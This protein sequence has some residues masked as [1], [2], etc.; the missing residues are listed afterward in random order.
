MTVWRHEKTQRALVWV[1]LPLAVYLLAAVIITWPLV[2]HLDSRA[3]GAGYGDSYEVVRHAWWARE[4][5]LDGKNPFD[6]PLLAYPDGFM[7]WVQWSHPLQYIPPALLALVVSPLTAFNLTLLIVLVLNGLTAYWLVMHLTERKVL[8]ALLGGLVFLAFPTIQGHL[9][10]GHLGIITLYPLPLFALCL[11]R[12]LWEG[13]GWR[14]AAWGA[15]WFALTALAYV[16]QLT[17][18]LFPLVLFLGL[19]TLAWERW[20]IIRRGAP[21]YE[22]PWVRAVVMCVAGG[23]LL[24][25]FYAPLLTET[26]RAELGDVA[27]TGRVTYSADLLAFVSPSPFGPLEDVGLLPDYAWDVLGTNSAEGSAY[28]GLGAVILAILALAR[29]EPARAWGVVALGAMLFS[30]GPLLKWRDK[31]VIF[32][33]EEFQSYVTLPWALFQKLPIISA[34]RTPGRFNLITGLAMS[35]LAGLGAAVVLERVRRRLVQVGLTVLIGALVLIEYQL[36]APFPTDDARQP[37]Y[38]RQLAQARDVRAVLDLPVPDLLA[39]KQALYLQT[40]HHHALVGGHALR[41]TPQDPAL[42]TLLDRAATRSAEAGFAPITREAVPYLLSQA[43]AD[44]VI[45][46]KQ[47]VT[48]ASQVVTWLE[49]SLGAPEFEDER[50]AVFAVPRTPEPPPDFSVVAVAGQEG[51]SE[52][53]NIGP[54]EGAFLAGAGD[55]YLYAAGEQYGELVFRVLPYRVP[56]RITVRLDD[57]LITGWATG[58]GEIRLPLWLEPGFHILRLV[59]PDG[60]TEY[61]FAL[62]CWDRPALSGD[63]TRL[64]PPVCISAAFEPPTW[65]PAVTTPTPLPVDLDHG[66]RLRAYDVVRAADVVEVRLF[67][68]ADGPLPAS[69]ALFVHLADPETGEPVAQQDDYPAV[70]TDAWEAGTRWQS[71]ARIALPDDLAAGAY[72]LNVGWFEPTSQVRLAVSGDRPWA[73]AGVVYLG[74]VEIP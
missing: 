60:C 6:Q 61:T 26:G 1:I 66:L 38:F 5:L 43:G 12:V 22:Q 71:V 55:W 42:L 58:G 21:L 62:T 63:C 56:R 39:A 9:S 57:H 40:L 49:T 67:W 73:S 7:S 70:L 24:L 27:E 13:A 65:V 48:D 3:A 44:R 23:I 32:T 17:F 51:W 59:A 53:V 72:A 37:D 36:F 16:S 52:A 19:Y 15:L 46:H 50:Y 33:V 20:R 4:A 47:F 41:R 35:V 28:L 34:S 30:L 68:E 18:V 8:P 10:V 74:L 2:K 54:F 14:T 45:L 25:P 64:D 31:P 29:R 11:W 69:Y